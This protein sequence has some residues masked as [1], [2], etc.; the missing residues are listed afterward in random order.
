MLRGMLRG[1]RLAKT[2]YIIVGISLLTEVGYDCDKANIT[3]KVS[4]S[5]VYAI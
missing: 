3:D 1:Y 4:F 2:N 5:G